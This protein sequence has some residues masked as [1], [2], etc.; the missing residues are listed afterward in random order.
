MLLLGHR[1]AVGAD[2]PENTLVAVDRALSL[3]ADGVEVDVRLTADGVPVCHHDASLRRTARVPRHVRSVTYQELPRIEDHPIPLLDDLVDL[4][5]DRGRLVIEL[6]T[7]QW[8]AGAADAMVDTVARVLRRHRL[9]DVVVSSFDRPRAQR[10]QQHRLPVRTAL[11]GRPGLP[12]HVVLGRSVHDG[13]QEAH[14]HVHSL[15]ARL[16]LVESAERQ[17]VALVGWT[18]D[19]PADLARLAAAGVFAVICDDPRAARR[20]LRDLSTLSHSA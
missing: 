13:H 4:V 3:G 12:L 17:G 9:H 20:A 8:P 19:R 14:P 1:G 5:A 15:L 7:P 10:V 16:D 2:A 11:I 6:K 18:A